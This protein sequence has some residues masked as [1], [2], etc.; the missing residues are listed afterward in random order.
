MTK[1]IIGKEERRNENEKGKKAR[2]L[3]KGKK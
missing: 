1:G 3:N 2:E